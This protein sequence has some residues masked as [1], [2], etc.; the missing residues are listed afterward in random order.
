MKEREVIDMYLC[1]L[2][3]YSA[4][5]IINNDIY[6][7]YSKSDSDMWCSIMMNVF[8]IQF[9]CSKIRKAINLSC[10]ESFVLEN[11]KIDK[12]STAHLFTPAILPA[13]QTRSAS[14]SYSIHNHVWAQMCR[15]L[16]VI[17]KLSRLPCIL[18][19]LDWRLIVHS[20]VRIATNHPQTLFPARQSV[21]SD[22]SSIKN[23]W[24]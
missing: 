17:M 6:F 12:I 1:W 11:A 18:Q 23:K 19:T 20:E 4:S 7:N 3:D 21:Y 13:S 5:M 8:E 22:Y 2:E 14:I 24:W 9:R 10:M 16:L 15:S